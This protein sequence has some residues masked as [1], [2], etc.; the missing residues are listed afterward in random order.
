MAQ[1]DPNHIEAVI[2]IEALNLA[3]PDRWLINLVEKRIRDATKGQM[4]RRP[5]QYKITWPHPLALNGGIC[6]C[7][8]TCLLC[9]PERDN[10]YGEL[11]MAAMMAIAEACAM[12]SDFHKAEQMMLFWASVADRLK[13][14]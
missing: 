7:D 13:D 11:P 4:L 14:R 8:M 6:S 5:S 2:H 12:M 1:K 10:E 9:R 3:D